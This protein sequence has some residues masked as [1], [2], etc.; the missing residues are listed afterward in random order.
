[1]SDSLEN[2]CEQLA[3]LLLEANAALTAIIPAGSIVRESEDTSCDK[4]RIV[5]KATPREVD[6][7]GY[8][9]VQIKRWRVPVD[10]TLHFVS[11][12]VSDMDLALSALAT[13]MNT[14]PAEG[15]EAA[16]LIVDAGIKAM[17][18]TDEG[19][20]ATT[21]NERTRT[22]RFNFICEP[23]EEDT[24]GRIELEV[25]GFLLLEA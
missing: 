8:T 4:D 16:A 22:K 24:T 20:F 15:G 2:R 13:A 25:G 14:M 21:D 23:T 3:V 9:P 19:D 11:P 5:C 18:D 6:S 17:D 1:M 12:K 10:I 7:R